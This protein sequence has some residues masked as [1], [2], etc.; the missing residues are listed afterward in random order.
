[1]DN[2]RIEK[3]MRQF[4][5]ILHYH[6]IQISWLAKAMRSVKI[7]VDGEGKNHDEYTNEGLATVGD[8][9]LKS[10][11]S[12]ML[13]RYGITT[14]GAITKAKEGI[15]NNDTMHKLMLGEDWI[16]YSYN[17]L[18]FTMDN[19]PQ[20]EKVVSKKHDPYIEAIVGAIYYDSNYDTTKRWVN[21]YLIPLLGKWDKPEDIEYSKLPEQFVLKANHGCGC[22]IIVKDKKA[23][24]VDEACRKM[25][26]WL[27]INYAYLCGEL[28]YEKIK[29]CI[30][31]E[32]F[33]SDLDGDIPDYK[34]WCFN[35]KAYY[36]MYLSDRTR[37][38]KMAFFDRNWIKQDFVYSY[39]Q[40]IE[41]VPKP[42][43]L[44]E[45]LDIAEKLSSG[46]P[47]V[48]VDLYILKDGSIKFGELTFTSAGGK[49]VWSPSNAD[50]ELGNLLKLPII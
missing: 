24:D 49:S 15:E 43:C 50:L 39:P 12:D 47:L 10:M 45:M 46:F 26:K 33:I 25:H 23:L 29:P 6:F 20:H 35:G 37:G 22:N 34:V 31:A 11:I 5:L 44:Q 48:R 7:E 2:K 18:H 41:Q 8:T 3:E 16:R 32:E 42:N 27:R 28:Q 1:M 4:E 38:L 13:Y 17:D 14:K 19:P 9:M 30:I 40:I 21:K 36:I